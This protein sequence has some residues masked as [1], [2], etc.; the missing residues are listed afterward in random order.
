MKGIQRSKMTGLTVGNIK[1]KY[2][3]GF[4]N[5]FV[6]E[7]EPGVLPEN[8]NSPQKVK[9]GLYTEQLSG[10][11]FMSGRAENRRTWLY[12]IYPSVGDYIF[13]PKSHATLL[14]R[15][16]EKT[17]TPDQIRWLPLPIPS[18]KTD[19]I[20]G[21]YTICG[22]GNADSVR[23]SALHIYRAN[24]SMVNRIFV[25]NDAELL[26]VPELGAFKVFT[27]IGEIEMRPGEICL[28]PPGI[29]FKIE[30]IDKEIRGYLLENFGRYLRLPDLGPI[31][32]NGLAY[33]EHFL[34]PQAKYENDQGPIELIVKF[35]DQ[36]WTA[37]LDHTPLDVVE[38]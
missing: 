15:P 12:R 27:E 13:K 24:T 30:L 34:C 35:Q 7:S 38:G 2:M 33:P 5:H 36:L 11:S 14:G 31:G 22:N 25:D 9:H 28:I 26:F 16:F 1:D 17:A 23:G 6:S 4:G 18:A 10:T 37:T 32:S 8:Q 3:S 21:L 19:F 29:K 20:D